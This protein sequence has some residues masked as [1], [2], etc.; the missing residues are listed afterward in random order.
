M[1]SIRIPVRSLLTI[2]STQKTAIVLLCTFDDEII[3]IP[4]VQT[5]LSPLYCAGVLC[6]SVGG[7]G[8]AN[9]EVRIWD[10]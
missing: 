5:Q 1:E 2:I 9:D 8:D 7:V 3:S 10:L 6:V 4:L